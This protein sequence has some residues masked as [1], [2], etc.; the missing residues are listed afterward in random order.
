VAHLVD[1]VVRL[2]VVERS[3]FTLER[4]FAA[5]YGRDIAEQTAQ[6]QQAAVDAS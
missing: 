2:R 3:E 4:S 1:C 5:K 6:A